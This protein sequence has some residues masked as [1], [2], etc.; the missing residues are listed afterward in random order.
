MSRRRHAD[1]RFRSGA[2]EGQGTRLRADPGPWTRSSHGGP[3]RH[4]S[5]AERS[6][7]GSGPSGRFGASVEHTASGLPGSPILPC[8]RRSV[9]REQNHPVRIPLRRGGPGRV[10][11]KRPAVCGVPDVLHGGVRLVLG[12]LVTCSFVNADT[13]ADE[14]RRSAAGSAC[15]DRKLR[16]SHCSGSLAC[17]R[18]T[19][20]WN[21]GWDGT[22]GGPAAGFRQGCLSRGPVPF[23]AQAL[24]RVPVLP[25][26]HTEVPSSLALA[27]PHR[28]RS[29]RST[30]RAPPRY[31]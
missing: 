5:S 23:I 31:L 6:L 18:P 10:P 25:N 7:L 14:L 4:G 11:A 22:Q 29:R 26:A 28:S 13:D 20:G 3:R 12:W 15:I 2:G 16:R 17:R 30:S 1:A 21:R 27:H 9:L 8:V 19:R 24:L